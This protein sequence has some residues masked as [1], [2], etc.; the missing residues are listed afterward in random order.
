[1]PNLNVAVIGPPE[2]AKEIG[3]KGT[4][5]DITYYNLKKGDLTVTIIEP[6]RYPDKLSSLFFAVSQ[7]LAAVVVIDAI[8]P[9]FGECVVM[10]HCS[11]INHGFLILRNYITAE[12]IAPLIRGTNIEK[13]RIVPDDPALIR[14]SLLDLAILLEKERKPLE[15]RV[16]SVS[17]D[18]FF[19]VKGIGTVILGGVIDGMIHRHDEVLVYPVKKKAII[20]SIQKHDDD[21]E[22]AVMYDRVGLALKGIEADELDRGYVLSNGSGLC[23]SFKIS[24]EL[25]VIK[26]WQTTLKEG[27]VTYIG[28]WMQFLPVR[29]VSVHGDMKSGKLSLSF[30]SDK[31]LVY[32]EGDSAVLHYL[33]GGKLR[34]I[35]TL[36][37][38]KF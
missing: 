24:G 22:D 29:I 6:T 33:E 17:I 2:Y 30:E 18:H 28:H 25:V 27:M 12:Q 4:S 16:G 8:T 36:T 20:R 14:Q 11:G 35:G 38:S 9:E 13:Y 37:L 15:L 5:T 34:I 32:R 19:N 1:M 26:Y 23:S 21:A 7:S 31:K 10:L 3:K